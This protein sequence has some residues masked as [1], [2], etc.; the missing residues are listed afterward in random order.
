VEGAWKSTLGIFPFID[1]PE[2]APNILNMMI[3]ANHCSPSDP[4]EID[5][6]GRI[7]SPREGPPLIIG[8]V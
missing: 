8:S 5:A 2:N 1:T 7:F 6:V 4:I 3:T